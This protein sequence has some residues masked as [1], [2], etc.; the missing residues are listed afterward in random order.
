MAKDF[1]KKP[2]ALAL[3]NFDG[4]HKGHLAVIESALALEAKGFTA[5]LLLFNKHPLQVLKGSAPAKLMTDNLRIKRLKE[6]GVASVLLD[7]ARVQNLSPREFVE[8]ILINQLNARALC[9]GYNYHFGNKA[10]GT[11][12]LLKEI[13]AKNSLELHISPPVNFENT[14]ISST[15]IRQAL[16]DGA[17]ESAN[18]M[19]GREFSYDFKVA[20]GKKLGRTIGC[21]TINQSFPQGFVIPKHGVY[22]SRA[23][24]AGKHLPAL[25]NIGTRPT[26]EGKS[27]R[28]E[29][30][31]FDY[32]GDLY[33]QN[34]EVA[35]FKYLRGEQK[36]TGLQDLTAQIKQDIKAAEIYFD[37]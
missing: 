7:F 25:T 26:F 15:R 12:Q 29:T 20:H 21:P 23:L 1:S 35:L 13:C 14:A 16:E 5:C 17:I 4:L 36:F 8:N 3:G 27:E 19:L 2:L 34:I 9:C 30:Y 18:A 28:S 10:R 22:F 24:V 32:C 6:L 31:I 11:T 33:G 37:R